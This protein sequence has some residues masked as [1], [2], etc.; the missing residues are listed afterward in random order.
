MSTAMTVKP[1]QAV[2]YGHLK[3]EQSGMSLRDSGDI[4]PRFI[5]LEAARLGPGENTSDTKTDAEPSS[6]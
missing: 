5:V 1:H 3:Q 2:L 6:I 4:F